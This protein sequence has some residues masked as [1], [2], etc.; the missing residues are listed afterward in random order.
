MVLKTNEISKGK[1]LW[2][3]SWLDFLK[4]WQSINQKEV[5]NSDVLKLRTLFN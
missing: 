1:S 4:Q 3:C 5:G 2:P